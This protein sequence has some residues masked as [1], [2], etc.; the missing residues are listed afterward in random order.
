MSDVDL[1]GRSDEQLL[2]ARSQAAQFL[3]DLGITLEGVQIL[4]LEQILMGWVPYPRA[5]WGETA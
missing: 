5:D 4:R 2:A 3:A 1:A